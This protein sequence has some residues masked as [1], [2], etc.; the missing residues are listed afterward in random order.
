MSAEEKQAAAGERGHE[1]R[2]FSMDLATYFVIS[3]FI[4]MVIASFLMGRMFDFLAARHAQGQP[5]PAPL[6]H[7]RSLEPPAP[8][9]QVNPNLQ[10]GE[11]RQTEEA[12]LTSYGWVQKEAGVVR[13]PIERAKQLLLE[14]G[15]PVRE[16]PPNPK[17]EG[18]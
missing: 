5:P 7:T 6:A 3:L 4:L 14:R 1:T 17:G 11:V 15:L 13:I 9:L 16:Q 12:L 8:R 10:L 2:D 18:Q